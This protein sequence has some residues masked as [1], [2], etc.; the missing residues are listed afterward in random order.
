MLVVFDFDS[1]LLNGESIDILAKKHNV[2]SAV[3]YITHEAME[4]KI[5]FFEALN[6][7]VSLLEGMPL[8][9][10]ESCIK[11]DFILNKGT[12]ECVRKLRERGHVVVCFS[13][14]FRIVVDFFKDTLGLNGIF[15][16]E[17]HHKNSKLTGR[18]GGCMMFLD[19]KGIM[20]QNL[21]GILG[22]DKSECVAIGDGANDLSMFAHAD[23]RIAFCA[24]D[25]LKQSATHHIDTKD[26]TQVLD[27]I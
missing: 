12:I 15:A 7:R 2:E 10:V 11:S 25:I 5:D 3:S 4:G 19:S 18:V 9:L 24:K 20:M 6:K 27:I 21:Q 17:L 1:T 23:T 13:G 8:S 14:G 26:L 16:N 22:Y